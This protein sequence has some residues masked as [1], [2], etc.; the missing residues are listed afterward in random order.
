MKRNKMAKRRKAL[1][2][3]E[4]K[5]P[6]PVYTE[7]GVDLG[8][9][10]SRAFMRLQLG[11]TA[12]RWFQLSPFEPR[13]N[14]LRPRVEADLAALTAGLDDFQSGVRELP[15]DRLDL[16]SYADALSE[17]VRHCEHRNYEDTAYAKREAKCLDC[18]RYF[19]RPRGLFG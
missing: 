8:K 12:G 3:P 19:T 1:D 16:S 14:D 18:G 13:V 17:A 10:I 7:Q 6:P 5:V 11:S 15:K 2:V 4:F 9:D